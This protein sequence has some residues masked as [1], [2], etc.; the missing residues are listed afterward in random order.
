MPRPPSPFSRASSSRSIL[1]AT[2]ARPPRCATFSSAAA[3]DSTGTGAGS[4]SCAPRCRSFSAGSSTSSSLPEQG[5]ALWRRAVETRQALFGP[6]DARTAKAKKGLAIS[7]ARQ[8]RHR[9]GRA[10]LPGAARAGTGARRQTRDGERA[11]ELWQPRSRLTG[12]Y[13]ASETLLERAVAL[14]ESAGESARRPLAEALNNLGLTYWR[15]GRER[16]AVKVIER[17]LAINTKKEGPAFGLG[18]SGLKELSLV[19]RDL[20][21]LDIAERYGQE[22]LAAGGEALS[23]ESPLIGGRLLSLG[24]MA[25]KRG[26]RAKAREFYERSIAIYEGS[27]RPID[28]GPSHTRCATLRGCCGRRAKRRRPCVSTS[29]PWP[30]G[31]RPSATATRSRRELA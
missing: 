2:P 20:N 4:P 11:V 13:A 23:A 15:Q 16:D 9:R 14:L 5:E 8:A 27:Q 30:C 6:G 3:S 28:R 24:Q 21:E 25:E 1:S 10:A 17:A 12:D 7:L 26:D 18:G 29:V 22:A 19:H 31:A